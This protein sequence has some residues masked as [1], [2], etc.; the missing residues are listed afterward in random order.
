MGEDMLME[1]SNPTFYKVPGEKNTVKKVKSAYFL[2]S[3]YEEARNLNT[4]DDNY[5]RKSE[6]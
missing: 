2:D 4:L 5:V 3:I 1:I 6:N